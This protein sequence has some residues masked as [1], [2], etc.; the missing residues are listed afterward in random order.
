MTDDRAARKFRALYRTYNRLHEHLWEPRGLRF[1]YLNRDLLMLAA[2]S[3][4]HD[5][6]RLRQFHGITRVD[7]PKQACYM[8]KWLVQV[9]PI[10]FKLPDAYK[11]TASHLCLNEVLALIFSLTVLKVRPGSSRPTI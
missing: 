3:Y 4:S 9:Q 11:A 7:E 5:I 6:E 2:R 1:I 8:T 10:Q